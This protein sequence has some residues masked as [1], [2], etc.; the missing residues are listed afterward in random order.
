MNYTLLNNTISV[1]QKARL[2]KKTD[3]Q[4]ALSA[5]SRHF[6]NQIAI[7]WTLND[8]HSQANQMGFALSDEDARLVLNDLEADNDADRGVDWDVIQ[9]R[10]TQLFPLDKTNTGRH[11]LSQR[12]RQAVNQG[13]FVAYDPSIKQNRVR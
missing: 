7:T 9:A 6:Q 5:L 11:P 13:C 2:L 10:I 12:Q 1:L 8:I 4:K 3:T